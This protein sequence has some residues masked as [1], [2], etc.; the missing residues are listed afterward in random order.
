MP[1]P[2]RGVSVELGP[3]G[4]PG[5]PC[6]ARPGQA[7]D[8]ACQLQRLS[9]PSRRPGPGPARL[10]DWTHRPATR[11]RIPD[12][13][14]PPSA[15]ATGAGWA[16]EP[17]V[18]GRPSI[19]LIEVLV[20]SL[21]P[22]AGSCRREAAVAGRMRAHLV[23]NP[24]SLFLSLFMRA[25]AR[26]GTFGELLHALLIAGLF[27]QLRPA[28]LA[29]RLGFDS[30]RLDSVSGRWPDGYVKP[31]P[32]RCLRL[33]P[34]SILSLCLSSLS[35]LRLPFYQDRHSSSNADSCLKKSFHRGASIPAFPSD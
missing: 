25:L 24:G 29:G 18:L 15:R 4:G 17:G 8:P 32:R 30:G 20:L 6:R 2:L 13:T 34:P 31:A 5:R 3:A 22:A 9:L 1:A 10:P 28:R 23:L 16:A 14:P 7:V 27:G 33:P 12:P 26:S 19:Q 35:S 21:R 11:T